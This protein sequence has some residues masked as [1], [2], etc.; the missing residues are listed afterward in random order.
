MDL[1]EYQ[2]ITPPAIELREVLAVVVNPFREWIM[3]AQA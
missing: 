1:Q 2:G 3:I